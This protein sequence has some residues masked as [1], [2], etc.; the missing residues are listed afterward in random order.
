M[1]DDSPRDFADRMLCEALSKPEN[2]RGLLQNAVP[3][4]ADGFEFERMWPAKREFL[5]G[6]WRRRNRMCWSRFL[7][8]RTKEKSGLWSACWSSIKP[9]AI[10]KYR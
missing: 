2:L 6:N 10:G 1:N 3:E 5:L 8:A 9:K 7:I 4:L